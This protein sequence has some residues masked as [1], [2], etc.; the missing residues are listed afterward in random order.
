METVI[1]K[2]ANKDQLTAIK[3]VMKAL[4]VDF[5]TEESSYNPEFLAKVEKAET[6]IKSGKYRKITPTDVWK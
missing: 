4:K 2:P 3:A 1:A 6:Q 5:T